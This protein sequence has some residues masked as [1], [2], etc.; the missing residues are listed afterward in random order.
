[1]EEIVIRDHLGQEVGCMDAVGQNQSS[2]EKEEELE[3]PTNLG[4][5][6]DQW[7]QPGQVS[8]PKEALGEGPLDHELGR[9]DD[10]E[11]QSPT[12]QDHQDRSELLPNENSD[13][14]GQEER[15]LEMGSQAKEV[16]LKDVQQKAV[17]EQGVQ[18]MEPALALATAEAPTTESVEQ[19]QMKTQELATREEGLAECLHS[20][21]HT[22]T[23]AHTQTTSLAERVVSPPPEVEPFMLER[24]PSSGHEMEETVTHQGQEL[25]RHE[26]EGSLPESIPSLTDQLSS[27]PDRT[28]PLQEAKI[29]ALEETPVPLQEQMPMVPEAQVPPLP[30]ADVFLPSQVPLSVGDPCE[31]PIVLLDRAPPALQDTESTCPLSKNPASSLQEAGG[32]LP[33]EIQAPPPSHTSPNLPEDEGSS[34]DQV[35]PT[36]E[37][38]TTTS[39]LGQAP[40]FQEAVMS[41]PEGQNSCD[42]PG[43]KL[44]VAEPTPPPDKAQTPVLSDASICP[45]ALPLSSRESLQPLLGTAEELQ[46][47]DAKGSGDASV[48]SAG[49]G[50]LTDGLESLRAERQPLL[51]E[52]KVPGAPLDIS[53]GEPQPKAGILKPPGATSQQAPNNSSPPSAN[54][55]C[56]PQLQAAPPRQ[57]QDQEPERGKHKSCQCCTLM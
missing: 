46:T 24:S 44:N 5:S 51:Q 33:G 49:A 25:S 27:L 55:A 7:S 13:P 57:G 23:Q 39:Q 14:K 36:S 19:S 6:C 9:R 56:S 31:S 2:L 32:A 37:D 34:P 18:E 3:D 54:T 22:S 38:Q 20:S 29:S 10:P 47:L 40:S 45:L 17:P 28:G 4:E 52:D 42:P 12:F 16:G 48:A 35:P 50:E 21:Q 11:G 1:M 8:D 53:A 43:E 30:E 15:L 41:L 26:V